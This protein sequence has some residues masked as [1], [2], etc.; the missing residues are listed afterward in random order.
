[1]EVELAELA[2]KDALTEKMSASMI[3]NHSADLSHTYREDFY[4]SRS[5]PNFLNGELECF[6]TLQE[7]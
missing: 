1:M 6:S 2:I 5:N 4:T 3:S 7:N